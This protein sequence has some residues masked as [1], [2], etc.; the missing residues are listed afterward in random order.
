MCI[1]FRYKGP[2]C[3]LWGF[4]LPS[5]PMP[6]GRGMGMTLS[7]AHT[8]EGISGCRGQGKACP[9]KGSG[10]GVAAGGGCPGTRLPGDAAPCQG[11][12]Q[13]LKHLPSQ[14]CSSSAPVPGGKWQHQPPSLAM[15]NSSPRGDFLL[16]NRSDAARRALIQ[17]S[18]GRGAGVLTRQR[19]RSA[20][21]LGSD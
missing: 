10:H 1:L 2:Q 8:G 5:W 9:G 13:L 14:F 18:W 6:T 19:S 12:K 20:G 16:L 15:G 11:R 3:L 21:T 17:P 4:S 7:Y